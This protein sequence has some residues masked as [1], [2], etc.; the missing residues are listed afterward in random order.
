MGE[1]EHVNRVNLDHALARHVGVFGAGGKS[2]LARAIARKWQLAYIEIDAIQHLPG[3]KMRPKDEIETIVSQHM[4]SSTRGWVT[5]HNVRFI[6]GRAESIIVLELPFRT[7]FWR[8]LKR[9]LHRAWTKELVCGSNTE[10]FKQ[11]LA[12]RESAI[13][14]AWNKR[15]SYGRIYET[16]SPDIPSVAD[17]FY[18]RTTRQLNQFYEAHGLSRSPKES[19][20]H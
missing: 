7:V 20:A 8:R 17:V 12:S 2:T 5:D 1:V 6:L 15:K 18:I 10:T 3:W 9:S 16:L 19:L 13:L 14:E 4:D 11:H